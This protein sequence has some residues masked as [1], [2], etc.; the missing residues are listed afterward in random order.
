M[1]IWTS[2]VTKEM[3]ERHCNLAIRK[4]LSLSPGNVLGYGTA[5]FLRQ[6]GHNRDKQFPLT[7]E[8]INVLLLEEH[9]NT[10]FLELAHRYKAVN[11]VS[12]ESADRLGNDE[13]NLAI[14]GILHHIVE[15]FAVLGI[16]A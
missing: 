11:R 7:V 15:A 9:F 2:V 3:L 12:C 6:G 10:A 13:V 16:G 4:A 8:G 1:P 14:K 5:F